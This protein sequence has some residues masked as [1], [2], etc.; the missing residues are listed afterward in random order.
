MKAQGYDPDDT[1]GYAM[2]PLDAR[3]GSMRTSQT[4]VGFL[5][6]N[7]MLAST[8]TAQIAIMNSGSVRLDDQISGV[9]LQR[10][11]LAMLPFGG[12]IVDGALK[13]NDLRKLI[14][15]GL[16]PELNMNG[17]HLQY[18]SNFTRNG[19][20]M[21]IDGKPLD[22]AKTYRLVMPGFLTGIAPGTGET[23]YNNMGIST[24]ADWKEADIKVAKAKGLGQND[25]RDIVIFAMKQDPKLKVLFQLMRAK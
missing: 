1:I 13:G 3:D 18:S 23:V 22:D 11:I 9:V 2:V 14:E 6:C 17:A 24:M 19:S 8:P 12:N 4:N 21:F 5:I 10:H 20:G 15:K 25:L 16:G 7:A